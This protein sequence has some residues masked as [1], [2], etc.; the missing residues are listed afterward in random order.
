M[1]RFGNQSV[2]VPAGVEITATSNS[3]TV[4]GPKGTLTRALPEGV[5]VHVESGSAKV[6][7][8]S[9]SR[10]NRALQGT[11][12]AHLSNMV[13]GVKDGWSKVLEIVGAGFRAEVK[14]KDLVMQIGYSHPVVITAPEGITFKVEKSFV[15]V[16][17]VDREVVGQ[18]SALVRESRKP[19]PYKGTGIKYKD[20]VIRRKAGKQAAK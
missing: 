17:G 7:R 6:T 10:T 12:R 16:E 18:T 4:K 9:E 15:T 8:A 13:T 20:E 3:L 11:T 1:A 19:E 5:T 2:T 14:G